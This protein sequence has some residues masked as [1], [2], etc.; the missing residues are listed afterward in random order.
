MR[1]SLLSARRWP[2]ALALLAATPAA[3]AAQMPGVPVL[4]GPFR[5]PGVTVGA[6]GAGADGT[7]AAGG[8][9]AIVPRLRWLQ[10]TVGGGY[11]DAGS[12]VATYGGRAAVSLRRF[13]PFLRSEAIGVAV[14]AGI[15]GGT[16]DS[17]TLLALP[18]GVTAGYRWVIGGTR[19]LSVYASPFYSYS[20][21]QGQGLDTG[22]RGLLRVAGGVDFS[23]SRRIGLTVGVEGG[24]AAKDLQPGP[25]ATLY[26]AGISFALR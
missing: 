25:R 4:Q 10:F 20:Q 14:F 9:V 3:A 6:F 15:G 8:A 2:A 21:S 22:G 19:L 17:V 1:H 7:R 23:L 11:A 5:N 13:L 18:A 26:A 16:R 12:S 24:A